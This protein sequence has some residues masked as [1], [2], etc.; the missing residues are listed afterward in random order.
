MGDWIQAGQDPAGFPNVT[1]RELSVAI[2]YSQRRDAQQAW[3]S[4][5]YMRFAYHQPNGMPDDPGRDGAG[6]DRVDPEVA[7]EINEIRRRVKLQSDIDK[8]KKG[9]K[10]GR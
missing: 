8:A 3:L 4:A 1:L 10:H 6:R 9:A 2:E 7:A 5:Q